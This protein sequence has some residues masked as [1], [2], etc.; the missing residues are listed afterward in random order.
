MFL[1][2][3]YIIKKYLSTFFVMI[4]LFI[5]IGILV[6]MAEKIDKFKE[7]EVPFSELVNYY[8]DFTLY[9]SNML[10][11]IFLFLAVIWF[12]SKMANNTEVIAMLSSGISFGRF[13]QP[14][15]LSAAV[16]ASVAF[17]GGMYVVPKSNEGFNEFHYKYIN[18]KKARD[19]KELY[20]QINENEFIYVS[21]YNPVRKRAN[22]FSIE[23]FEGNVLVSK[24]TANTLRWIQRDSTFRLSTVVERKFEGDTEILQTATRKDTLF[25]FAIE[26]LSPVTYKAETLNFSELNAFIEREKL[27][28]SKLINAHLLVRHKR[29][30]LPLSAFVLTVI[31]VAMSSFKRRGGMGVNLALGITLGF[32]YIFFDKIFGVLV[33][34]ANFNPM[35]AAWLPLALFGSLALYLLHYAKR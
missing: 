13:L 22:N 2:D 15:L 5:P 30:S 33:L 14:Y 12:T 31:A 11:P 27:S 32:L 17:L 16:I 28:G 20:K 34:K 24:L 8:I 29:W 25:D 35:I 26:E 19:T 1:L 10:F 4:M 7:K 9:F 23:R 6:D 3:R 21:N 18:K